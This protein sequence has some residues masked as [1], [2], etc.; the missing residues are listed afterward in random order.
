M[1]NVSFSSMF[2][3]FEKDIK[4]NRGNP[5]QFTVKFLNRNLHYY[6]WVGIYILQGQDLVL[7]TYSGPRETEHTRIKLGFGICGLAAKTGETIVVPDVNKDPRYISCFLETKSE[8]VVPIIKNGHVVG[9]I[10][11]D[12]DTLDPFTS[13]DRD[14]LESVANLLGRMI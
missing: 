12:S 3:Q 11:I 14:F 1:Q 6:N 5:L 9:E 7:E 2:K 4:V 8:I 10:D 13:E